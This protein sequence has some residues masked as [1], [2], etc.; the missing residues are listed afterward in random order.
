MEAALASALNIEG[1]ADKLSEADRQ[2]GARVIEALKNFL[3]EKKSPE[4]KSLYQ[5]VA[6]K[7]DAVAK[8]TARVKGTEGSKGT[9][10]ALREAEAEL[11]AAKDALTDLQKAWV[12]KKAAVSK[13]ENK[14]AVWKQYPEI[15]EALGKLEAAEKEW[16]IAYAAYEEAKQEIADA[17]E[18]L[19]DKKEKLQA[20]IEKLETAKEIRDTA[21]TAR[22]D[23]NGNTIYKMNPDAP[24]F[25]EAQKAAAQ[26]AG[27]DIEQLDAFKAAYK[28][29][30]AAYLAAYEDLAE[31]KEAYE[32]AKN[33][34]AAAKKEYDRLNIELIVAKAERDA[35]MPKPVNP[36]GPSVSNSSSNSSSRDKAAGRRSSV[37]IW[38][39]AENRGELPAYTEQAGI[40]AGIEDSG[41]MEAEY[42]FAGFLKQCEK[43]ILASKPM[44]RVSPNLELVV[45]GSQLSITTKT[46]ISFDRKVIQALSRR[47]DL[48]VNLKFL[49]K[50][51]WLQVQ[52]P[53]GYDLQ[54]LLNEE[55]YCGFLYLYSLFGVN[56]PTAGNIV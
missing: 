42:T 1:F 5:A 39:W 11:E 4:L 48:T 41:W 18:E 14:L 20:A 19:K 15:K 7:K 52:I 13:A 43:N 33:A 51:K 26:N 45:E 12:E 27:I 23:E 35:L 46:W 22:K 36:S 17:K 38:K 40:E 37:N 3:E 24:D 21:L 50:G 29:A 8:A 49:Y 34:S 30:Y 2:D 53:A 25:T 28:A 31:K 47:P 44:R 9:E 10:E 54:S 55:G 56:Q 16:N 6:D 32:T